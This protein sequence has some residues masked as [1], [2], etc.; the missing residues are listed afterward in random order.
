MDPDKARGLCSPFR[1]PG[2]AAYLQRMPSSSR[3][4]RSALSVAALLLVAP[5]EGASQSAEPPAACE[6]GR[7]SRIVIRNGDVFN[8]VPEDPSLLRWAYRSANL[9]H[10]RTRA[11]FIRKALIFDEGTCLDPQLLRES[12]GILAGFQ[13]IRAASITHEETG[14]GEVTVFVE[15]RDEWTTQA[16][17]DVAYD[18]GLDLERIRIDEKSLLGQGIHLTA[19]RRQYRESRYE[20]LGV[21]WPHLV[22]HATFLARFR[23]S[24]DGSSYRLAMARPFVGDEGRHSVGFS[25][26]RSTDPFAFAA[27]AGG[28]YSHVLIPRVSEWTSVQYGRRFG[29]LWR[30]GVLGLVLRRQVLSFEDPPRYVVA[31]H[32]GGGRPGLAALPDAVRRRLLPRGATY[33]SVHAGARAH[34]RVRMVGLEGLRDVQYV[35]DGY[36]VAVSAGRSL[37]VLVPDSTDS[38]DA[39]VHMDAAAARPMGSSYLWSGLHMEVN[40]GDGPWRDL[41][42][43]LEAVAYLRSERVPGHTLFVRASGAAGWRTTLPYQLTL[44]GREGVRSLPEDAW[45]GGRSV[46]LLAEDRILVGWPDWHAFDLGATVF[47][48]VG[49]MWAGDAPLGVPSGWQGSIGFGL[50]IGSPRG[51]RFVWRPDLVFP[52]GRGGDPILRVTLELNQLHRGFNSGK[53]LRS[54]QFNRG[55][56][57]F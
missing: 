26:D 46:V 44:G 19:M 24:A 53:L 43:G 39:F 6:G 57:I 5:L 1:R 13:F 30:A 49:R 2:G 4:W 22:R 54:M 56:E 8:P 38:H 32:F 42:A 23:S 35:S 51:T 33:L 11:D 34:T 18:E 20:S 36:L 27:P 25:I 41:L 21:T 52:L 16:S 47:A 12:E 31:D 7:I 37:G 15:T 29:D 10:I 9:L 50:R 28:E 40:R 55:V 17:A 45:P 3:R 14:P 48:D